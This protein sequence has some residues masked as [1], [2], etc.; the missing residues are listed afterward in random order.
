ML[1]ESISDDNTKSKYNFFLRKYTESS[2]GDSESW[3][4]KK[5]GIGGQKVPQKGSVT[6]EENSK[7]WFLQKLEFGIRRIEMS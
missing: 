4:K 5:L 3:V 7:L 2:V 1:E 6:L